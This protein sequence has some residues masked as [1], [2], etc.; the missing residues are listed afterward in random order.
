MLEDFCDG[1]LFKTHPLLS[2]DPH[3]IQIVGY[4]DE[5]EVCNPLGTHTKKH[6]L[7]IL[8]FTI[9][10]IPPKYRST[11]KCINLI[12]CATNPVVQ[13]HG[14][15]IILEPLIKDLNVLATEGISIMI[16]STLRSS[17]GAMICFIG[18]NLAS[19]ALGG[20]KESF[21]FAFRFCRSCLV[22]K[23]SFCESFLA[24][25]FHKRN[26]SDH[27]L[28][29]KQ[30]QGELEAHYSKVHGI[31]RYSTL[32]D[33]TDFTMCNGGLPHDIMHDV[34]EG[35]AQ[36]EIKLLIRHCIDSKYFTIV[37]YNRRI[38]FFDYGSNET[39]KPGGITKE[40]LYSNDKK[41]HLSAAQ[42]LL[43]CRTLPLIIGDCIPETNV[44]WKCFI[45]LL[46]IIDILV[47]PVVSKG[48]CFVLKL[49]IEEHHSTF[50]ELYTEAALMPK[51]HFMV[52]YPDQI[53]ALG[54][55]VRSWTM[56]YEAKLNLF[57][58]ASHLGNFKNIAYTLACRHQQWMCYQLASNNL[59]QSRFECGPVGSTQLLAHLPQVLISNIRM[60][61]PEV[62]DDTSITHPS[63]VKNYGIRYHTNNCF[64]VLQNDG[65]DAQFGK[66][67]TF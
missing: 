38:A 32:L 14:L 50:K 43:L 24:D 9:T 22:T 5:L 66:L 28:Y 60:I 2:A 23:T 39:D 1:E 44:Y 35:V 67:L 11:L 46:K 49:L 54:P 34:M 62:S 40:I 65:I 6:K 27:K 31:N 33:I 7:V 17:K 61:L 53:I 58:K 37:E 64:V 26:D 56:R 51:F 16:N 19:N 47:S 4:I 42:T 21:S 36:H 55:M 48:Q 25:Y 57:K 15:D 41:F 59:L 29:C 45:L 30:I 20:F 12:A 18:D 52:H 10:N 63:W 3:A 13:E 8:L